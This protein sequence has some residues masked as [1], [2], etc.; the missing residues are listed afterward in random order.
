MN[1]RLKEIRKILKLTQDDFAQQLNCSRKSIINYETGKRELPDDFINILVS[2]HNINRTWL[3]YG[4]GEMFGESLS[5]DSVGNK[6]VMLRDVLEITQAELAYVLGISSY[7]LEQYETG[8]KPLYEDVVSELCTLYGVNSLW[9]LGDA[10]NI[11]L[12]S[13]EF[14]MAEQSR[15]DRLYEIRKSL[16]ITEHDMAKMLKCSVQ[17][18]EDYESDKKQ[19]SESTLIAIS[20][21][22]DIRL[23][24]LRNGVGKRYFADRADGIKTDEVPYYSDVTV[25]EDMMYA[26][27]ATYYDVT[28]ALFNISDTEGFCLVNCDDDS[29]SPMI[30]QDDK[31]LLNTAIDG[32]DSDGFY[33]INI[34]D[35]LTVRRLQKAGDKILVEADNKAYKSFKVTFDDV[36]VVGKVVSMI[37]N[38]ETISFSNDDFE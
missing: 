37:R 9:L 30:A 20:K 17:D 19:M 28:P 22:L 5:A 25:E 31:L 14:Y 36:K 33:A 26:D 16:K 1:N 23:E 18:I 12:D 3:L 8:K 2:S 13:E 11:F 29:M 34:D 27:D 38:F 21:A 24:W 15:S 10:K 32:F 6:L 7:I 4:V 35:K